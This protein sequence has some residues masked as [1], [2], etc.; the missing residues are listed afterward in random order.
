VYTNIEEREEDEQKA[1]DQGPLPQV[2][3]SCY[4]EKI[5]KEKIKPTIKNS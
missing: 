3:M 1:W 5:N 4:K 2:T